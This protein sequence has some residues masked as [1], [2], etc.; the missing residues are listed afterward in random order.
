MNIYFTL[1]CLQLESGVAHESQENV[2]KR[3]ADLM[4]ADTVIPEQP[5][6]GCCGE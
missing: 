3:T 5:E 2:S 1:M 4:H 6:T